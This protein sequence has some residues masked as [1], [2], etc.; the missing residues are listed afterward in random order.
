[1]QLLCKY[2]YAALTVC[3]SVNQHLPLANV[4]MAFVDVHNI[5]LVTDSSILI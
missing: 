3:V 2:M 5:L 4:Q 1:M